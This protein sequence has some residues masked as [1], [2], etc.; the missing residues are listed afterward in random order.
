MTLFERGIY[1]DIQVLKVSEDPDA[2]EIL[3]RKS[4]IAQANQL[5]QSLDKDLKET[6]GDLQTAER[7]AVNA[8]QRVVVEKAKTRIM[9]SVFEIEK[10][11]ELFIDRTKQAAKQQQK[12]AT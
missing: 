7:K 8:D 5:I 11:A 6:Q 4:Q 2:E 3:Q 1:D 10:Y 9:K 12:E